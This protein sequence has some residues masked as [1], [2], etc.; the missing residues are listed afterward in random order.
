MTV[1]KRRIPDSKSAFD[2]YL[3]DSTTHLISGTPRRG[4]TLGLSATEV[5]DWED[6]RDSWVILYP[7]YTDVTKRTTLVTQD[8]N[9]LMKDFSTFAEPLLI[10]ISGS[11][12]LT[13]EDRGILNLPERDRTPSRKGKIEDKPMVS[14]TSM[15]GGQV[16]FR[17]R[18]NEDSSRASMHPLAD[19]AE[20]KYVLV[21]DKPEGDEGGTPP[22]DERD[23]MP[24]PDKANQYTISKKALFTLDVGSSHTGHYIIAFVRWVNAGNAANSGPWTLPIIGVIL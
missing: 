13:N 20:I 11:S 10:R 16:K 9:Q 23:G 24:T 4:E 17:I 7:K 21:K 14:I 18:G 3:R 15:G 8:V 5:D 19:F 2:T 12:A 22:P 1:R 6:Y